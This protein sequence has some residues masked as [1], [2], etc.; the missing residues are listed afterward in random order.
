M[1]GASTGDA[2]STNLA[3]VRDVL[4]KGVEV[5][6]INVRDLVTTERTWLLLKLLHCSR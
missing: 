3:A 1:L 6:V 5:L 2:T 4:A